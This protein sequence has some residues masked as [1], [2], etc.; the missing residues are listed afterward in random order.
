M[1]LKKTMI[2]SIFLLVSIV[3]MHF[4]PLYGQRQQPA[5]A[6]EI[7][8]KLERLNFLG[9][10]LYVAAHPDDEN[11]RLIA[12]LANERKAHTAYLSMTRGDGG[13]N[14][15]GPEIRE[16]LGIIRTQELLAARRIDGGKQF[17]TRAND[18]G[19]SKTAEETL[20][21][22]DQDQVLS[23]VVRTFRKFRPDVIITRFPPDERAGH[24]HHTT[25]AIMAERA[26]D[27]SGDKNYYPEQLQ[28]LTVWSPKRLF[29]NTG[30]WWNPNMD[31]SEPGV[32]TIDVGT[33]NPLLGTT[34]TEMAALSRSQHK[35]QGFGA[36]G[37]RG[38]SEEFLEYVKGVEAKSDIFEGIDTSWSRV[39]GGDK[40]GKSINELISNFDPRKP[41]A[42]VRDMLRI[43]RM[44]SE[45]EDSFW[46]SRKLE[47]AD[48]IIS[49]MTGLYLEARTSEGQ[50]VPGQN[51][52]MEL[53]AI[54]QSPLS[55]VLKGFRSDI[56]G[57]NLNLQMTAGTDIVLD[58]A[59]TIPAGIPYSDPYWLKLP[60]KK[61]MYT[62]EDPQLIGLPENNPSI[63]VTVDVEIE[64]VA[65]SYEIPLQYRWNDPVQGEKHE[66]LVITPPALVS[67]KEAV[68]LFPDNN[69]RE[70]EVLV[71]AGTA[72]V[73]GEVQLLG[74]DG[75][76]VTPSTRSFNLQQDGEE[77]IVTFRVSPPEGQIVS[78][79][80]AQVRTAGAT[81][82]KNMEVI[83]YEHIPKQVLLPDAKSRFVHIPL[84]KKGDRVGYIAGAGD[85]IPATLREI[86]Y[87]V[88]EMR[89]ED[90]TPENLGQLDAIILGVRALNTNE[91]IAFQMPALL[92][93]VKEGGTLIV[94]YNTNF[95]L[96]TGEFAPYPLQLSRDRVA[97]EDAEIRIL[98]PE[99]PVLNTP[100]KIT[101]ADFEGWVQE[102]GLYFPGKWDDRY[103]A[104]LSSND[105]GESPLDG[106]LLVAQYGKGY[107]IYTGY[108]WF[109][110]LPAGVP[111][112]IRLFTNMVSLGNADLIDNSINVKK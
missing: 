85:A 83:D 33:Y 98:T 69:S 47:Q 25:S 81:Y 61:G 26:F 49:D 107:Y 76:E 80:V 109:R 71:K 29:T 18:F 3:S 27:I 19:Y 8:L 14:L 1:I 70:I 50:V 55:V 95:R 111:G 20:Q 52:R 39:S 34:Y 17:F 45:I 90:V 40:I 13:Q 60:Q 57:M 11:T 16:G 82:S 102:R 66:P 30:R 24:G 23:D 74:A 112:A 101:Q 87:Q 92:D 43:R 72:N 48:E 4:F 44:I 73:A 15:I 108:S 94:Q 67:I 79:L 31:G 6:S 106:G 9:T 41:Y 99:H 78:D 56:L 104:I 100:N 110:E 89:D 62:V 97:E 36:T 42:S 63:P 88:W 103:T 84:N 53:E 54:Q 38:S 2:R 12:Y 5:S 96:K 64:G 58:T 21:V 22:W 65:F 91:R 35:S 46:K 10:V 32:L 37:S 77:S 86:G 93:Y 7:L 28:D 68:Y 59:V 75:W 51:I 105:S